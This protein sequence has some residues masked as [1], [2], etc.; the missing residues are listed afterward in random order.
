[1]YVCMLSTHTTHRHVYSCKLIASPKKFLL[2][3][4]VES[5]KLLVISQKIKK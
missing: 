1:M 5:F 2:V 4:A 3:K